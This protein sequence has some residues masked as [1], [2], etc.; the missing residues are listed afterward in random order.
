MK[1]RKQT[2]LYD[3]HGNKIFWE[4]KGAHTMAYAPS[5]EAIASVGIGGNLKIWEA[6]TGRELIS[7]ATHKEWPHAIIFSPDGAMLATAAKGGVRLWDR[8]TG[9]ELGAINRGGVLAFSDDGKLLAIAS[10]THAEL[11]RLGRESSGA[12]QGQKLTL[13]GPMDMMLSP[14]YFNLPPFFKHMRLG[15]QSLSFTPGGQK[16]IHSSVDLPVIWD[17]AK[18]RN[19]PFAIPRGDIF[20]AFSPDGRTMA[21]SNR[22]GVRLWKLP[23]Y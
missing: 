1:T 12:S 9:A 18:R 20:L 16:L 23:G 21:T 10:G 3:G 2:L 13:D 19:T 6:S 14:Y 17:W 8:K 11:W 15:K 22:D 7:W 5:G 4:L